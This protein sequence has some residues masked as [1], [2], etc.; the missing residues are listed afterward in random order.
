VGVRACVCV[1]VCVCVCEAMEVVAYSVRE[2]T[3]YRIQNCLKC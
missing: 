3:G 1:C 2:F